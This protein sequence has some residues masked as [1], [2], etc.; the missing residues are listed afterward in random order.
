MA[1]PEH[2][3]GN[4]FQKWADVYGRAF[5]FLV[6]R[7]GNWVELHKAGQTFEC[8]SAQGVQNVC[9]DRPVTFNPNL[10][11]TAV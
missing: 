1:L 3:Q 8:M 11:N 2:I 9:H 5:G 4:R 10:H 6:T 7:R